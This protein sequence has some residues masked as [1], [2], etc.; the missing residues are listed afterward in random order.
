MI[1]VDKQA[2]RKLL[3]S[4]VV[5]IALTLVSPAVAAASSAGQ[6][7]IVGTATAGVAEPILPAISG[8]APP[9][10]FLISATQALAIAKSTSAV[11]SLHRREHPLFVQV[12]VWGDSYW[13]VSFSYHGK[14]AAEVDVGRTGRVTGIWT[15]PLAVVVYARGHYAPVFDSWWVVVVSS[16]LFLLPFVDL[17]RPLRLLHLDA[18]VLL[19]FLC[20]YYLFD[21]AHLEAAVWLVYPPLLYLLI[22]MVRVGVRGRRDDGRLS[23]VLSTRV[24]LVGVL[25]LVAARTGLSLASRE[26]VDVGYASVLGAHR[27]LHGQSLYYAAAA[28]GDTY[29]PIA[30]LAYVPFELLFPWRGSWD[31]LPSA[32]A[33]SIAFDLITVLGLLALGRRLGRGGQGMRLGL[34]LAWAWAACPFTLLGLMMHTNDG[35]VAMLAVLSVLAFSSPAARGAALA[36]AA[37][38]KFSP[39]ALLPLFAS[40]RD[41]GLKGTIACAL[42][43]TA[44]LAFAIG[45]YLPP[46]GLTEFY[47]HTIGYQ[48]TRQDVFSPWALHPGLSPLKTVLEA[49]A[50]ALAA[51]VALLPRQRS[52]TQVCALAAAVT[53][54]VQIPAVHWFYYYVIWFMPFVLIAL[55]APRPTP[56]RRSDL[57]RLTHAEQPSAR[58]QETEPA[59]AGV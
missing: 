11:R 50:L 42:A 26:V 35:L 55:L 46:G 48:L 23:P 25:L 49:L 51:T 43:F 3:A 45:L 39:G 58:V 16:L 13:L 15:G 29:G 8:T 34:A 44:V 56:V 27:I 57:P 47:N 4:A 7:P 38:A 37:A 17:R 40:P 31:Y 19:S 53:I 33:A 59:I 5:L 24:L 36:V 1:T 21:H 20:S 6:Q 41:R 10:H 2:V 28:H 14:I 9:P 18:L 22:R 30:Y 12:F 54:A 52:L 32:H